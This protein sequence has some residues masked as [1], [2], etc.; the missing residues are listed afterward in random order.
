MLA[1]SSSSLAANTCSLLLFSC[2]SKASCCRCRKGMLRNLYRCIR[3]KAS[4]IDPSAYLTMAAPSGRSRCSMK[5]TAVSG[6]MTRCSSMSRKLPKMMIGMCMGT[7]GS[8]LSM[9]CQ[10]QSF[11]MSYTKTTPLV[12][13]YT[14]RKSASKETPP[15]SSSSA[16]LASFNGMFP[17]F[18]GFPLSTTSQ[19]ST[20]TVSLVTL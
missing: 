20:F 12:F 14:S 8:S 19:T 15:S 9:Y 17:F 3:P 2:C 13:L 5:D 7:R 10:V 18:W 16:S 4:L 11:V 1:A 6:V